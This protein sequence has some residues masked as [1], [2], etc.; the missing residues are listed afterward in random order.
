MSLQH[1]QLNMF[2]TVNSIVTKIFINVMWDCSKVN[3]LIKKKRN[4]DRCLNMSVWLKTIPQN[5]N[6]FR[7]PEDF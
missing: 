4:M 1:Q 5:Q 2:Y 6:M 7:W 3:K